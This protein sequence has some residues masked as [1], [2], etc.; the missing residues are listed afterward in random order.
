MELLAVREE[1]ASDIQRAEHGTWSGEAVA[2][3]PHCKDLQTIWI[4]H[5]TLMPTRKFIQAE[6]QIYHDC[7]SDQPCR[8][9][10]PGTHYQVFKQGR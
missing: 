4:N 1:K 6:S 8:L 10:I 9:Y 2:F 5:G 3:C 7:G